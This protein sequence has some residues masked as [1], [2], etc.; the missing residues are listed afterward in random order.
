MS[1]SLYH[2]DH[3]KAQNGNSNIHLP[4]QTIVTSQPRSVQTISSN[5]LEAKSTV[6]ALVHQPIPNNH[7]HPRLVES[8]LTTSLKEITLCKLQTENKY[9]VDVL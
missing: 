3:L 2:Q 5:Q 1:T 4:A 6:Q 9:V 7:V 8:G